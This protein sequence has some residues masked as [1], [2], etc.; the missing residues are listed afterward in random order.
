MYPASSAT[1]A[2][3]RTKT[4]TPRRTASA[5]RLVCAG[6]QP[7]RRATVD[8]GPSVVYLLVGNSHRH[9]AGEVTAAVMSQRLFSCR[10]NSRHKS[11]EVQLRRYA[12]IRDILDV[13]K[14]QD[15]W[16]W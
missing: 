11:R 8:R 1:R 3:A 12:N 4:A 5:A 9:N 14:H 10:N 16:S 6:Q 15:A 2:E 13:A 7:L